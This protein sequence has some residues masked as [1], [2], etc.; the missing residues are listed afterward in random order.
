MRNN[1][2]YITTPRFKERPVRG[3]INDFVTIIFFSENHGYRMK[4]Y[5]P[6][7]MIKMG[8]KTILEKQIESIKACFYNFEIIVCS[9]FETPKTVNYIKDKFPNINIRVVE[10]Q[11]H[12][13]SNCCESARLCLNNTSNN[14]VLLCSG[15]NLLE[16]HHLKGLDLDCSFVLTQ[17]KHEDS[18]FEINAISNDG[19]LEQFSIGLKSNFWTEVLYLAD[20][21]I[22][23]ALYNVLSDP[24]YKNKFL[25]EA[26]NDIAPKYDIKDVK[27]D[28]PIKK[29]NNIKIF[30]RIQ[31]K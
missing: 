30:K 21:K 16:P 20:H 9:G 8:S 15:S 26:L 18:G 4:S 22:I 23:K 3:A 27:L 12:F 11:V 7:S 6:V 5:G 31:N 24:E 13:N 14:K 10:N 2:R 25:F 17:G 19:V 28:S 29:I 1:N